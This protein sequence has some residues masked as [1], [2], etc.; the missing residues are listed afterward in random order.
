MRS[1]E[2]WAFQKQA[3]RF[4]NTDTQAKN[5]SEGTGRGREREINYCPWLQSDSPRGK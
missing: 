1:A 2:K 3:F 4:A 5:C